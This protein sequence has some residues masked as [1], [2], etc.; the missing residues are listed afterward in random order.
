MT[1]AAVI[2]DFDGLIVD[3]ETPA[4][5]AWSHI[6]AEFGVTLALD[7]WVECVGSSHSSF[8]PVRHLETLVNRSLE[9][10]ALF[11]RKEAMK[12]AI[13]LTQPL[14]PGVLDRLSEAK[15]LGIPVAIAS[16]SDASWVKGHAS[17]LGIASYIQIWRTKEDVRRTKPDPELY[18]SAAQGLEVRPDLCMVFEDSLNGVKAAKASGAYCVAVP[19][20]VTA[21]LDFS[22][23]DRQ[24]SSLSDIRLADFV[25]STAS[26]S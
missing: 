2:F 21:G 5:Q 25:A 16:S 15:S 20:P 23:A 26:P 17:R 12:A 24:V 14:L 1:L 11:Q 7:V 22:M 8:D 6:Y 4:Y 13:C 19:N 18:L 10:S 9:R 3:T